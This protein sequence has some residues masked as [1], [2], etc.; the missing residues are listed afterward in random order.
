LSG[1]ETGDAEADHDIKLHEHFKDFCP[2]QVGWFVSLVG[3]LLMLLSQ[4]LVMN[5]TVPSAPPDDGAGAP[6]VS[7][8]C[9]PF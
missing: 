2:G 7:N 6:G 3:G 4:F 9:G 1:Q 8:L 5:C